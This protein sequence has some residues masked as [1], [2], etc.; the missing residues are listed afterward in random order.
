[1]F[2]L[3]LPS[4]AWDCTLVVTSG[5][6]GEGCLPQRLVIALASA[7]LWSGV[8]WVDAPIQLVGPLRIVFEAL[9]VDAPIQLGELSC[10]V[11]CIEALIQ[12][13]ECFF[14]FLLFPIYGLPRP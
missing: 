9:R 3:F 12:S 11:P 7:A 14:L 1:M 6:V 5:G 10:G 8:Y 4:V 13:S 2:L